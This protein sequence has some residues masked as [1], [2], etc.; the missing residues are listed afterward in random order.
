MIKSAKY[1][2]L[3]PEVT[4]IGAGKFGHAVAEIV[5]SAN[6][7][8]ALVTRSESRVEQIRQRLTRTSAY[9]AVQ[10]FGEMPLADIVFLALPSSDLPDMAG[11]LASYHDDAGRTYVSL[12]K[13]VTAPDGETPYELLTRRFGADHSAVISGPSLADEMAK[14]GAQLVVASTNESL[15]DKISPLVQSGPVRSLRSHDP[16]GVE[17]AGIGKNIA[18][19]GFHASHAT[20]GSLN[21]AGAYS[22]ALYTEVWNYAESLGA[23]PQSFIGVAGVGDLMTTSHASSSRNARAGQLLGAGHSAGETETRI[24]QAIESFHTV[25]LLEQRINQGQQISVTPAMSA[26]THRIS[27]ECTP[28]AWLDSWLKR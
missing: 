26:L 16:S 9:L 3:P 25:P 17:W 24:K 4:V 6:I 7:R 21:I 15:V 12:S 11:K 2:K 8:T 1:D 18:T 23:D 10:K 13:G 20:T 27:G 22:S 28:E 14:S 19:L 5:S